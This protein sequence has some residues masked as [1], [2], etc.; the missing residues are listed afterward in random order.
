M[1]LL[2]VFLVSRY[3]LRIVLKNTKMIARISLYNEK[4]CRS[5]KQDNIKMIARLSLYTEKV[6]RSP[7]KD[8]LKMIARLS[9]HTE[10]RCR[11]PKYIR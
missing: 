3:H 5:H 7:K 4:R 11:R 8:N 1:G 2:H 10:K 6:Y 9:L